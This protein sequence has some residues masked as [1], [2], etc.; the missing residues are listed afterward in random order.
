[1]WNGLGKEKLNTPGNSGTEERATAELKKS[2]I[3]TNNYEN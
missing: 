1:M 2:L 3:Q